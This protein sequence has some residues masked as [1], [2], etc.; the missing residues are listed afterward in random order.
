MIKF[1]LSEYLQN[2]TQESLESD[3]IGT[4]NT[5]IYDRPSGIV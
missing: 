5:Q 1:F 4:P 3:K 2:P